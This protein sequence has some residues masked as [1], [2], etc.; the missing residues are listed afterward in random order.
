MTLIQCLGLVIPLRSYRSMRS[1]IFNL[2]SDP[3]SI[4]TV[5]PGILLQKDP[6]V[7]D[8]IRQ[9]RLYVLFSLYP[10]LFERTIFQSLAAFLTMANYLRIIKQYV[11]TQDFL[12]VRIHLHEL[13][14][15]Q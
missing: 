7:L 11:K 2:G 4:K 5:I 13:L 6:F 3:L 10:L 9:D 8:G 14:Y 12:D 1:L 15:F